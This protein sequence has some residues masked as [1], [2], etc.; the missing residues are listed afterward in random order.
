MSKTKPKLLESFTTEWWQMVLDHRDDLQPADWLIC[1]GTMVGMLSE[2]V[3]ENEQQAR[4][5]NEMFTHM[6]TKIS[7]RFIETT[8]GND[9]LH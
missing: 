2:A 9:T 8:Y 7:Y 1:F 5:A 4:E 6:L 3:S